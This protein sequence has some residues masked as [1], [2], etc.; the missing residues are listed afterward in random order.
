V[1]LKYKREQKYKSTAGGAATVL[2]FMLMGGFLGILLYRC[3]NNVTVKVDSYLEKV[4][5]F[6]DANRTLTLNR[7][8]SE[9]SIYFGYSGKDT[10]VHEKLDEYFDIAL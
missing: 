5:S 3:I 7:N 10:E 1:S 9:F 4:N 6:K 8:N 2:I